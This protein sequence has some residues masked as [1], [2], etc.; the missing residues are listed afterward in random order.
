MIGRV[1]D[2]QPKQAETDDLP[3]HRSVSEIT[4]LVRVQA[5]HGRRDADTRCLGPLSPCVR[6]SPQTWVNSH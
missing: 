2:T 1:R 3:N 6:S 4:N 5:S